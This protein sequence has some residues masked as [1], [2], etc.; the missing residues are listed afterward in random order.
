MIREYTYEAGVRNLERADRQHLP[1]G[2]PPGGRRQDAIPHASPRPTCWTNT[3]A[4]PSS[5]T[6]SS[7]KDEIGVAT[8]LAWTEAGGDVM[9]V[10]VS[11]MAGKGS[12]TLTGQLGE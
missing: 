11:L 4:R 7:K 6:A 10:E 1:Q 8:G 12:L 3:W 2:G 9:Q 5:A